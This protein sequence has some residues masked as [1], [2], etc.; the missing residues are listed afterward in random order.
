MIKLLMIGLAGG[1][2]ALSRYALGGMTQRVFGPNFPWGTLVVNITG[3]LLFG[4]IWALA[5]QRS[6]ITGETRLILLTGFMGSFTTF[7]T[8]MFETGELIK[9][10]QFFLAGGNIILSLIV[11]LI[12]LFIGFYLAKLV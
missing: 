6:I 3:S 4:F 5:A 11:G 2:G 10:G 1:L 9:T 12:S 7:S 8:L